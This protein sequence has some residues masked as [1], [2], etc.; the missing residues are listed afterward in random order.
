[1]LVKN[2]RVSLPSLAADTDRSAQP[3]TRPVLGRPGLEN[4]AKHFHCFCLPLPTFAYLFKNSDDRDI[5]IFNDLAI[6]G[7]IA[8]EYRLRSARMESTSRTGNE[9]GVPR[10]LTSTPYCST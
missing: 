4:K 1:M 2:P 8:W 10:C 3:E 5:R 7:R 6:G 9:T